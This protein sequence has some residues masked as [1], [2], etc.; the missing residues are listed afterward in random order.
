MRSRSRI[1]Y[2]HLGLLL[3]L[4]SMTGCASMSLHTRQFHEAP[5]QVIDVTSDP[6]GAEVFVNGVSAGVTPLKVTLSRGTPRVVLRFERS[7]FA[8][9]EVT[10]RRS[11]NPWLA[12]DAALLL[13]AAVPSGFGDNPYSTRQKVLVA[14]GASAA[15][16][17]IDL[18]NK[19]AFAFPSRVRAALNPVAAKPNSAGIPP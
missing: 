18:A 19:S 11:A 12:A 3:A 6:T 10:L 7:G 13:L 14:A 16:F 17:A 1:A 15:A 5:R 2:G 9:T 8:S 4:A